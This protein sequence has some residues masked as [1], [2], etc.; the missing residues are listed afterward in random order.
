MIVGGSRDRLCL[1]PNIFFFFRNE[2][3]FASDTR[4]YSSNNRIKISR[5]TRKTLELCLYVSPLLSHTG[6]LPF[7]LPPSV[8]LHTLPPFPRFASPL[9]HT[10]VVPLLP[11]PPFARVTVLSPPL[12]STGLHSS[13][14]IMHL[15]ISFFYQYGVTMTELP[16]NH[17]HRLL[18]L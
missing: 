9:L 12:S 1:F 7:P 3:I 6:R 14:L 13:R 16:Y 8:S 11:Q 10:L 4:I 2:I 15:S 18:S 17:R 5:V